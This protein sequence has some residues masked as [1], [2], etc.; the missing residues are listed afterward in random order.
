MNK[1]TK[2][3]AIAALHRALRTLVQAAAA[4]ALTAIGGAHTMGE[5]N[6]G[7]VAS[8]AGLAAI[9]SLLTSVTTQ[10]PELKPPDEPINMNDINNI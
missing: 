9:M 10:L 2:E 4:A 8:M 6:W 1:F 3:W 7:T 5:V